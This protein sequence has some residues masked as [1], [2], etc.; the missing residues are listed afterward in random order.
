MD[1]LVWL[2]QPDREHFRVLNEICILKEYLS[3]ITPAICDIRLHVPRALPHIAQAL[4]F[5]AVPFDFI[6]DVPPQESVPLVLGKDAP[7][8]L[9]DAAATAISSDCDLIWIHEN[10][11]FP[12]WHEL[13]SLNLLAVSSH[14]LELQ[15]EI[16]VRGHDIPWTFVD[17]AWNRPWTTFYFMAENETFT[18][19]LRFLD[20]CHKKNLSAETSETGRMLIYNRL[21]NLCFTRDRL[22]FYDLERRA[23]S[24]AKWTRQRFAF[25]V[26]YFLEFYY[27][28]IFG[29]LDSIAVLLNAALDLGIKLRK[30]AA[31]SQ[32]FL[33]ALKTK[34]PEIHMA[35]VDPEFSKFL[36]RI[37]YLRHLAAHRGSIMP[38]PVYQKPVVEPTPEELDKDISEEDLDATINLSPKGPLREQVRGLYRYKM[39]IDRSKKILDD[40]ILIEA[41]GKYGFIRPMADIEWNF[42]KFHSFMVR[43]LEA[44]EKRI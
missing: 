40:A 22:L 31:Q 37:A 35:F 43:V 14:I 2:P 1:V 34:A 5:F 33:N 24:R 18:V 29:G 9:L 10:S 28:L 16:F 8:G 32:A 41:K 11:W 19:G 15:C 12:Y 44:C 6:D 38:G 36:D 26:G 7:V 13:E 17:M 30:V 42:N 4:D 39:K 23:A 21:S 3:S 27:L 25:E 20:K